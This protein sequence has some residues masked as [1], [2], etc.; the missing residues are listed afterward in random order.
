MAPPKKIVITINGTNDAPTASSNTLTLDEDTSHTFSATEFGFGDVD[1]GDSLQSVTITRLP[2]AGSLTL[3]GSAVTADQAISASDISNLVFTPA[4]NANGDSYADLQF[5]VSD[6]SDSSSV[7]TLTFDVTAVNDAP[8][9]SDNILTI[10]EDTSHTFTAAN[11]GFSDVDDGDSMQSVTITELPSAGSLTLNGSAVTTDQ[12]ISASDIGNLVFTPAEN[13]NGDSYADM[14]FTVSDG[15]ASS[16]VQTLTFDVNAVADAAQISG[17][18][19][20][21]SH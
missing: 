15:T 10:D 12:E 21:D 3:N 17:D 8:T 14:Q 13:A 1:D 2:G 9:A 7:Q 4:T 19:T 16:S 5:T 6:G 18:D 11:F 20:G